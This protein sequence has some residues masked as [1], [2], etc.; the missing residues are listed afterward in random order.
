MR[1]FAG[2]MSSLAPRFLL[3]GTAIVFFLEAV[4]GVSVAGVGGCEALSFSLG[5]AV[6][7]AVLGAGEPALGPAD[8]ADCGTPVAG[9]Y[10]CPPAPRVLSLS[11][12]TILV[13]EVLMAG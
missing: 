12:N 10:A 8:V 4:G 6:V 2:E 3:P 13:E 7:L 5:R 11:F 1:L 9:C